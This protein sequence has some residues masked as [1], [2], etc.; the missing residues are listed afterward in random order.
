MKV[1]HDR[2]DAASAP[3][4]AAE[5]SVSATLLE[6]SADQ[7]A[8]AG[9]SLAA[10]GASVAVAQRDARTPTLRGRGGTSPARR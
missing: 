1:M 4:V 8:T 2:D 9:R 10:P 6:A 3:S 5:L 7:R